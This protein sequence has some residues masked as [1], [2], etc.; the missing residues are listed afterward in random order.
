M[1]VS[2]LSKMSRHILASRQARMSSRDNGEPVRSTGVDMSPEAIDRRLR[3]LAQLY[4][5]GMK[6]ARLRRDGTFRPATNHPSTDPN[7]DKT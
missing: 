7:A 5:F 1:S 3:E 6:L 4:R 2:Y